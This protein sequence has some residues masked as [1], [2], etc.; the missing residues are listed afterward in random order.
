MSELIRFFAQRHT[1]A[2]VFTTTVVLLGFA[3]LTVIQ[4]DNFPNVD[5]NTMNIMTRYAGA[6]P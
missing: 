4:R 1:L 6:S 5:F 2:I 3:S